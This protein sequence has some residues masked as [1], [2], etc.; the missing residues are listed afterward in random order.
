M[1]LGSRGHEAVWNAAICA[2]RIFSFTM[3]IVAINFAKVVMRTGPY[4]NGVRGV[5]TPVIL[6]GTGAARG[7]DKGDGDSAECGSQQAELARRVCGHR[8]AP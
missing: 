7:Q 8:K 1:G 5:A 6:R 2:Y 3:V 4:A